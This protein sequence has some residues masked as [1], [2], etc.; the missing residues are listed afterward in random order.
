MSKKLIHVVG[1][2]FER[3]GKIMAAQR[4]PGRALEWLLGVPGWED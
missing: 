2:V 1:A 4:G 3:E